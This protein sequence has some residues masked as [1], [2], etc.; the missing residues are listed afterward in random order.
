[1]LK[2]KNSSMKVFRKFTDFRKFENK[3]HVSFYSKSILAM[4]LEVRFIV[5]SL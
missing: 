2:S 1:M 5:Y 4:D 3:K